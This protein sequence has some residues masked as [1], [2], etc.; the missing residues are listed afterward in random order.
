MSPETWA[1][2]LDQLTSSVEVGLLLEETRPNWL[3]AAKWQQNC[4]NSANK[5]A[6]SMFARAGSRVEMFESEW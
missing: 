5:H 6:L 1:R 4:A 3:K 2:E